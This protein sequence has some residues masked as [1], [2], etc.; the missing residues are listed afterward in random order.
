MAGTYLSARRIVLSDD[1]DFRSD[2]E[3][4]MTYASRLLIQAEA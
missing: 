3:P 1:P 2:L 4:N